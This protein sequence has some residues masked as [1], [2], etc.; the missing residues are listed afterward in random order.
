[1]SRRQV[2]D[3]CEAIALSLPNLNIVDEPSD[4]ITQILPRQSRSSLLGKAISALGRRI[5]RVANKDFLQ[6]FAD[7]LGKAVDI[8]VCVQITTTTVCVFEENTYVVKD[9]AGDE[10]EA[11]GG[12][13]VAIVSKDSAAEI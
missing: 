7:E 3:C 11:Q 5:S 10:D 8:G 6:G 4:T 12:I 9:G 2:V 1:L 13:D